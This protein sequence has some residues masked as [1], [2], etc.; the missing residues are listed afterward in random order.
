MP[1]SFQQPL[2]TQPGFAQRS[3][4][5]PAPTFVGSGLVSADLLGGVCR[6]KK[7]KSFVSAPADIPQYVPQVKNWLKLLIPIQQS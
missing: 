3:T 5:N 4:T 2:H 6:Q 1:F 7:V